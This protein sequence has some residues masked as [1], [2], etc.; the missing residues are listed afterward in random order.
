[1]VKE[2]GMKSLEAES[3]L[4][5]GIVLYCGNTASGFYVQESVMHAHAHT[6]THTTVLH[7]SGF[8]P[9]HPG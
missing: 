9:G 5:R 3:C 8:C 1:M 4:L 2:S 6:H 7:L